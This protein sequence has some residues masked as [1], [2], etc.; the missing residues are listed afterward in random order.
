MFFGAMPKMALLIAMNR[1]A[2]ERGTTPHYLLYFGL[3]VLQEHKG[4]ENCKCKGLARKAITFLEN[5]WRKKIRGTQ[6]IV[7]RDAGFG[8]STTLCTTSGGGSAE[9]SRIT[10]SL[11]TSILW[12]SSFFSS[13]SSPISVFV[14]SQSGLHT[15]IIFDAPTLTC[16]CEW[17]MLRTWFFFF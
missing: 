13:L 12:Y 14:P 2:K 17:L 9:L 3:A 1:K 11:D 4:R 5:F 10:S 7:Q 8:R 16:K 6:Q 15:W